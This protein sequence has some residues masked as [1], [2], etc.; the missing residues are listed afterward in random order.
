MSPRGPGAVALT[1]GFA[2]LRSH[3]VPSLR[4]G[5]ENTMKYL[6]LAS[7]S[8]PWC[9]LSDGCHLTHDY[10]IPSWVESEP[11]LRLRRTN[12]TRPRREAKSNSRKGF[13]RDLSHAREKERDARRRIADSIF[14]RRRESI[15]L[16]F[17]F[18]SDLVLGWCACHVRWW[19]SRRFE[20][21]QAPDWFRSDRALSP[22]NF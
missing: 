10:G 17:W 13:T 22:C 8:V 4:W 12:L 5:C 1:R 2:S 3:P 21:E 9:H 16:S 18:S 11:P 7:F 20:R 15:L 6:F 14:L 19:R